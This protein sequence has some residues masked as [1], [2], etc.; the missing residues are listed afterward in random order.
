MGLIVYGKQK[1]KKK[2]RV[3]VWGKGRR[4]SAAINLE[5]RKTKK[6]GI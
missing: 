2:E 6:E 4:D 5:R 1:K 3:E